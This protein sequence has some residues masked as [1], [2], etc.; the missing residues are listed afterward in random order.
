MDWYKLDIKNIYG[1]LGSGPNG[2]EI[3][4]VEERR[5]KYGPNLISEGESVSRLKIILDQFKS[6]LIYI[7]LVSAAVTALLGEYIDTGVIG[8]VL[9]INAIVGYFQ[10][11]KAETSI[12][13]LKRM[14]VAKT[15]VVRGGREYEIKNEELVPGD[16]IYLGSGQKVPADVRLFDAIELR[17]DEAALT[18]ESLPV[19]K[20]T[21]PILEDNL[22]P[23]DQ[24]NMAF[25]GTIVV[26][27]R[28]K[29]IVVDTG[30]NTVIGKIARDV[31]EQSVTQTPLQ[32]KMERFAHFIGILVLG[33]ALVIILLGLSM[34]IRIGEIFTI[35]VA[36]AV[37]AVPEGLPIVVTVAMAI[38]I[39]RMSKRNAVIRKLPAV[40]TLGSTSIICTDKTGTLTK[41]EMT[42]KAI[43]NG[44]HNFEVT[45]T[46]YN[47]EGRIFHE[48]KPVEG[49]LLEKLQMLLRIGLLCNESNLVEEEGRFK[50]EGDPTE[51]AL[52]VSAIKGGL[53]PARERIAY[54]LKGIIPFESDRGFMATLHAFQGKAFIFIKGGP[55]I[56]L[57]LCNRAESDIPFDRE[58]IMEIVN[59]FAEDGLRVLTMAF[60]EVDISILDKPFTEDLI[61]NDFIFSGLQ[62]MIDPPRTEVQEA[63]EGCKKAGIRV[64]M[65]TGDHKVTASAIGRILHI[66]EGKGGVLTG[67]EIEAMDDEEL[68][69]K[70]QSTSIFARV[71]PQ[72]KLRIVKQYIRHG[73]VVAVTGDGVNDAPALK[74][75]HIGVAMG[76]T[77]TDVAR[78]A[79]DMVIT[80]DN[81]TSIFHA[82]EEGR[83][84]F[85]NIRKVVFFLIP[86]GFAAIL[87]IIISMVMDLP[88]PYVASQLLWIN[89]VTNGLQDVALAFEP[90]EKDVLLRK[91]R[92]I[93]EG[94][95]S[96][97]LFERSVMVG[98][99]ISMGIVYTYYDALN[100]G[101]SVTHA[102]TIAMTTMVFFQFFQAWNSRSETRSV[103][104]IN[105]LSNPFL[106]YSM[107]AALVAQIGVIYIPAMQWLFRT[108]PLTLSEWVKVIIVSFS[109]IILVEGDKYLRKRFS[110]P[111]N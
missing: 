75:A 19:V 58:S 54:S 48:W 96:R 111:G 23:G 47:P 29:G 107:V 46:G 38:G 57:S 102:R 2:L 74:A 42:V 4:E 67:K 103:F 40:E 85:D 71:S 108:S 87:S 52:I 62:A 33:S 83:I 17:I 105:P 70:V 51:A 73:E 63:I 101:E 21:E 45:G 95:M 6:P 93:K 36:A 44:E 32:Q 81:F 82:V 68:Y 28:G 60:K 5:K 104:Q 64:S 34:G 3:H 91:P 77:G 92:S 16:I 80:D 109:V 7:L 13:A 35:A 94:I 9:I 88:V 37:A 90:G 65:I 39:R 49:E 1:R 10:E 27:G 50:V 55:E 24:K 86:T 110:K 106:F 61:G 84:V 72:H 30:I 14:I 79:A 15:K 78:E 20:S 31:K 89:L 76:I 11:Y 8:A 69:R 100:R 22:S 56:I 26:N 12:K 43:S 18:G 98:I 97:L 25:M 99:L 53:E 66:T 59:C 41:N